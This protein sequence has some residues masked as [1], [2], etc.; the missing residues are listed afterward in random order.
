[1]AAA[2]LFYV[3]LICS[4]SKPLRNTS[5]SFSHIREP[6]VK[7]FCRTI[8]HILVKKIIC[9]TNYSNTLRTA[10]CDSLIQVRFLQQTFVKREKKLAGFVIDMIYM[11]QAGDCKNGYIFIQYTVTYNFKYQYKSITFL[12]QLMHSII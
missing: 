1:M 4:R 2:E 10:V 7:S 8:L 12:I 9:P 6:A 3:G 11:C 5:G